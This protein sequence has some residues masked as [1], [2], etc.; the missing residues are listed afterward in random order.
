MEINDI[1][2]LCDYNC[3]AT[4]K[5]MQST[6]NLSVDQ[7]TS[8]T[9]CSHGSLRGTIVHILS[10]EWIWRLRCQEG[11][12]PDQFIDANLFKTSASLKLRLVDEQSKIREFIGNQ[13]NSD[14]HRPIT[15]KTTKGTVYKNTLWHIMM[16]LFNHGTHHRSEVADMLSRYGH[17]P[18]D[19]DFIIYLRDI[20]RNK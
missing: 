19:I 11:I 20:E 4:E 15:Y 9:A 7:F 8:P 10:A 1:L 2:T 18:G 12:S 17:S 5:I 3:W 6:A 13:Q 16:H 14:L